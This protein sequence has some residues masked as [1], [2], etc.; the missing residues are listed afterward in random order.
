MQGKKEICFLQAW[1]SSSHLRFAGLRRRDDDGLQEFTRLGHSGAFN[2][3]W[4]SGRIEGQ[5]GI[6][7]GSV[8]PSFGIGELLRARLTNDRPKPVLGQMFDE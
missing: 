5:L 4:R 2:T 3:L 7:G 8:A 6:G 1:R